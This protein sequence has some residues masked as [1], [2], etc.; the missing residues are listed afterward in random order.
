MLSCDC[1]FVAGACQSGKTPSRYA[2]KAVWCKRRAM[3]VRGAKGFGV[4]VLPRSGHSK[5]KANKS[6]QEKDEPL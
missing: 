5:A 2:G 4:R 6:K 1:A 3:H